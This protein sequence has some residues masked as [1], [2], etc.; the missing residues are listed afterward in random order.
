MKQIHDLRAALPLFKCLSSEMRIAILELLYEKG[1]MRMTDIAKALDVTAGTLSPHI[2][3]LAESGLI[4]LTFSAGKHGVQRDCSIGDGR[5]LI[6]PEQQL[7][8][9]TVYETEISIG[10]YIA[11][12]VYPTCGISTTSSVI[13][14]VDDAR[15]FAHQKHFEADILWFSRGYVEYQIPS[16]IPYHNKIDQISISAELSSEAPGSNE[17]W[18]SDIHFYLNNTFIGVWTS[19]GD[20]ADVQ[21]LFTPDWWFANWNQYGLLK[22]LTINRNGVFMDNERLSNVSIDQLHLDYRDKLFFRMEVPDS[23][24]HIGGLTVFGRGFGNYN[25]DIE[26]RIQYSPLPNVLPEMR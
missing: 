7:R 16:I 18:P 4:T 19:P 24:K 15:Y 14:E 10:Q 20:Y 22:T 3:M 12:E 6:D 5:I 17:N 25:Q 21:G 1:T 13:G 11:Y 23:A 2:K 8:S 26:F 9:T